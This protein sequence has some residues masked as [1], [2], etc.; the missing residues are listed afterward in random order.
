MERKKIRKME[1]NMKMKIKMDLLFFFLVL[2]TTIIDAQVFSDGVKSTT[3]TPCCDK[4][5]C[6]QSDPPKCSCE[7]VKPTCHLA[8]KACRCSETLP[9]KCVCLDTTDF[10][11]EPCSGECRGRCHRRVT[12]FT[13]LAGM[14][15]ALQVAVFVV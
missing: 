9:L 10:C 3:Y 11:Y 13:I 14:Y 2:A 7:D 5:I 1:L 15:A 8:C 12:D 4:C 6:A